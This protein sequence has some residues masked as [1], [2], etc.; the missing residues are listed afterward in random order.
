MTEYT[1]DLSCKSCG[2]VFSMLLRETADHDGKITC[3]DCS[4]T[5]EYSLGNIRKLS[6]QPPRKSAA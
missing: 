5:H 4:R 3:P 1:V 6:S 2:R